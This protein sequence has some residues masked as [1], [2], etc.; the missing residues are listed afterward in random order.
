MVLNLG[1]TVKEECGL[2]MRTGLLDPKERKYE[3]A[4]RK[5]IVRGFVIHT[6]HQMFILHSDQEG[7]GGGGIFVWEE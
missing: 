4:R 6:V 7:H 3:E 1:V 5:C 2:C